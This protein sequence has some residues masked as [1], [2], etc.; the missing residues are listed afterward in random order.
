MS[1]IYLKNLIVEGR[2]GVHEHEKVTPQRFNVT[3][4]LTVDTRA[5]A[6]SD[7]IDDTVDWSW[8]RNTVAETVQNNSYN[9]ME[10]LAHQIASQILTDKKV[11]KITV[12]V[13]KLDA[14]ENGIPGVQI[15]MLQ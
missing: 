10:T 14:F 11:R 5:A 1:V 15:E 9:L 7:E 3:V 13:D 12:R 6:I 2:H 8:V 4:K